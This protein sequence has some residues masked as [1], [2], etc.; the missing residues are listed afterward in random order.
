VL[1]LGLPLQQ[2]LLSQA[3]PLLQL[4]CLQSVCLEFYLVCL[5]VTVEASCREEAVI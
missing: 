4:P 3:V 5:R 1:E 2:L